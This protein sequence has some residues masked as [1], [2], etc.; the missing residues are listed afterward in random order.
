MP[1]QCHLWAPNIVAPLQG[2]ALRNLP[3]FPF[4]IPLPIPSSLRRPESSHRT[5]GAPS[6]PVLASSPHEAPES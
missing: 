4:L 6:S 1:P 3:P 2:I 5:L